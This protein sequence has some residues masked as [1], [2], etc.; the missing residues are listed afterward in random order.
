MSGKMRTYCSPSNSTC[1]QTTPIVQFH[2]TVFSIRST[3]RL[4]NLE[5]H[6]GFPRITT[7]EK[8]VSN[9]TVRILARTHHTPIHRS[10]QPTSSTPQPQNPSEVQHT[11]TSPRVPASSQRTL[12]TPRGT[13][14]HPHTG[15]NKHT[16]HPTCANTH[17]YYCKTR[18]RSTPHHSKYFLKQ[19]DAI[20]YFS[21]KPRI[22]PEDGLSAG[23]CSCFLF[24]KI[25]IKVVLRL[26][27][28]LCGLVVR[29]SGYRSGGPGFDSRHYQIF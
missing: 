15:S 8:T 18:S 1:Y 2:N 24:S 14:N 5:L 20:K 22:Q 16:S 29:V 17:R 7:E 11:W 25:I 23:T 28:R 27:D 21:F 6:S 19:G 13:A 26:A 9:L 3:T 12:K 10:T 4:H